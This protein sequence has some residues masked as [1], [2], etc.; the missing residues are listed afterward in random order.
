MPTTKSGDQIPTTAGAIEQFLGMKKNSRGYRDLRSVLQGGD[1]VRGRRPNGVALAKSEL[2]NVLV[3]R[4]AAHEWAKW[5]DERYGGL[6][7]DSLKKGRSV[8]RQ[9]LR[10]CI[11]AEYMHP[12][13]IKPLDRMDT[14]AGAPR[15]GWLRPNQVVAFSDLVTPH[16]F[17]PYV[18]FLWETLISYGLR[19][20]EVTT[21]H[22]GSLDR[23]DRRLIVLGKGRGAAKERRIQV[24]EEYERD[25][26]LYLLTNPVEHFMFPASDI[27][28]S[29]SGGVERVV[30]WSRRMS[31]K[32][33]R[34]Q[35]VKIYD[36]AIEEAK[37]GRFDPLL[38]PQLDPSP[39]PH[40]I[41]PHNLR[42]TFACTALISHS[43][44]LGGLDLRSLQTMMGHT[45]L[46]TTSGYLSTADEWL[47]R[48][49]DLKPTVRA[50]RDIMTAVTQHGAAHASAT[51]NAMT[52]PAIAPTPAQPATP[53]PTLEPDLTGV[54]DHTAST[55]KSPALAVRTA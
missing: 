15:K 31:Q 42:R 11:D 1:F 5:L 27:R 22:K 28:L 7:P 32:S 30:D 47:Q 25:W 40:P 34:T 9:F 20:E 38:I 19:A 52:P 55:V 37:A 13:R 46:D 17:P 6:S 10:Y 43:R 45:R 23:N 29:G 26:A 49:R 36:L 12:D 2:G 21:L 24:T 39:E 35:L 3:S 54:A 44:G 53:T 33:L 51:T 18:C 8:L 41:S 16:N 50:A 4:P 48:H 14:V